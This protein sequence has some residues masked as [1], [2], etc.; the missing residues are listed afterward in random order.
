MRGLM[1]YGNTCYINA[2]I[3]CLYQ[4]TPFRHFVISSNSSSRSAL[5]NALAGVFAAM[6]QPTALTS[7]EMA[8]LIFVLRTRMQRLH[9][10]GDVQ[11]FFFK[12]LDSLHDD[13]KIVPDTWGKYLQQP[14]QS[15]TSIE[16]LRKQMRH[17]WAL[18]TK[19]GESGIT[20][21][22][23]GQCI[24]QIKCSKCKTLFH[25]YETFSTLT[26][27]TQCSTLSESLSVFF[28][29]EIIEG[30]KCDNCGQ[31]CPSTRTTRL[32]KLPPV[33]MITLPAYL[34]QNTDI[35]TDEDIDVAKHTLQAAA[36]DNVGGTR[37][38]LRAVACHAGSD[39][40]SGHYFAICYDSDTAS[41]LQIDDTS[42]TALDSRQHR[43]KPYTVFYERL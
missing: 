27:G 14:R 26:L 40:N 30:W 17:H 5:L 42:V 9:E 39:I 35:T 4:C 33:L 3:Q 10:Q 23:Y 13:I 38:G 19:D 8:K 16:N 32:W 6:Q 18:S 22:F 41:W 31:V 24:T 29:D 21:I 2:A 37:Y 1:N 12:L 34:F 11:E 36:G 7:D 28:A 20:K 43:C 15:A 25:S